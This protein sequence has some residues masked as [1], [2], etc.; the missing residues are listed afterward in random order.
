MLDRV[1]PTPCTRCGAPVAPGA[2]FCAS[3]AQPVAASPVVGAP[4]PQGAAAP[5]YAAPGYAAPAPAYGI[6]ANAVLHP[7]RD[8]P[9]SMLP[10]I[11]VC[12]GC[13]IVAPV[14]RTSCSVCNTAFGPSPLFAPGA[15]GNALFACFHACDFQCRSCGLRTPLP[16]VDCDGEVECA[17]CATVQ[18]FDASQW[19]EALRHA[20]DTVD[21]AGPAPEGR[22]PGP[23]SIA[24]HNDFA[25]IGQDHTASTKEQSTTIISGGGMRS[26]TLRTTVSPGHPLCSTCKVPLQVTLAHDGTAET[27]CPR[28]NDRARYTMPV[29]AREQCPALR[30][31]LAGEQRADRPAARV[32]TAQAGVEAIACPQCGAALE[33]GT[34]EIVTCSYCRA[35]ARVPRRIANRGRAGA[36]VKLTP[37]WVL[38]EGP[39]PGRARLA[40][41]KSADS[42][43]DDEDFDDDEDA[44]SAPPNAQ[45]I[46]A[47][48][49]ASQKTTQLI[50]VLSIVGAVVITLIAVGASMWSAMQSTPSPPPRK[51]PSTRTGH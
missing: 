33:L 37:F 10:P 2:R 25:R 14:A 39:S 44:P 26:L 23:T 51:S 31:V 12:P 42:D 5:G 22:F 4:A 18:A 7:P 8:A 15:Y 36:E 19:K 20:H 45:Q 35:T 46:Q 17:R 32:T 34:G 49:A 3:C 1:N 40:H 11:R 24:A 38:L 41:G 16:T 48:I 27:A 21:L 47:Q 43:D 28:C 9:A 30:A 29:G 6:P 50:I 13:G